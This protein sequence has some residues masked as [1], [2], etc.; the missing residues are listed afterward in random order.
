M[1]ILY[2]KSQKC[3]ICVIYE[4][5]DSVWISNGQISFI[6]YFKHLLHNTRYITMIF[7]NMRKKEI[8]SLQSD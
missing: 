4:N 7:S 3:Q 2:K 5:L 6:Y 8:L 1:M